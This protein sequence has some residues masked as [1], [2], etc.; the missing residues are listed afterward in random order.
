MPYGTFYQGYC[1][2]CFVEIFAAAD[3]KI[4]FVTEVL[5][6]PTQLVGGNILKS[7]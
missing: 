6:D 5:G 4:G 7:Y 2:E 1:P 3:S